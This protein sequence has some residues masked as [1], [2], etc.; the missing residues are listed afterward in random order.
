MAEFDLAA[1]HRNRIRQLEAHCDHLD[2]YRCKLE[3]LLGQ[4]ITIATAHT[5]VTPRALL[6]LLN[7]L[8]NAGIKATD[9]AD[10]PIAA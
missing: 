9:L 8:D 5:N 2:A 3:R 4:T 1:H 6:E 10:K 7:E